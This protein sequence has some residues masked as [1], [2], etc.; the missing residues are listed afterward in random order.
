MATTVAFAT[1]AL[2]EGPGKELVAANCGA[3]HSLRL[4]VA[5]RMDREKWL[6]AIRWMQAKHNLWSFPPSVEKQIL[7]YLSSALSPLDGRDMD[8]LGPRN[9]NPLP[10]SR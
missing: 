8:G 4:V 6:D 7:D 5:N 1:V 9:V 10:A 2:P 3:C